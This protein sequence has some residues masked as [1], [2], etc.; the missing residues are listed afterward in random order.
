MLIKARH[1]VQK[2]LKPWPA[3]AIQLQPLA[4]LHPYPN[5]PNKHSPEQIELIKQSMLER[6]WTMPILIDEAGMILAGH[7]RVLAAQLLVDEGLKQFSK[8]PC[9]RAVG[10]SETDKRAYVLADNQLTRVSEW[11]PELLKLELNELIR[12]DYDMSLTGFD[13]LSLT[14]FATWGDDA[15]DPEETPE[16]QQIPVSQ[17]GD[18]WLLGKHRLLCGDCTKAKD[19][20]RALGGEA[21]HLMVTDP[22]YGVEYAAGWRNEAMPAKNDPTRWKD[23][24]G[25]AVGAVSNDDRADWREAWSRFPGD[26]IYT[27]HAGNKAHIVAEGLL[28]SGFELRAQI[29]W[30]KHQ[31]VIGRGHYHPQHEPCWYA[32]RRGAKGHWSG[33]RKQTTVWHIDK[34]HKS[35]TG[36]ST[37][38]PVE[39][40]K[41]PIDNNSKRGE[42]VYDPFVGSGT[43]IIAAE[44]SGRHC[45]ALE[46]NP[47]YVDVAVRRWQEFTSKAATLEGTNQTFEQVSRERLQLGRRH[48]KKRRARVR[49]AARPRKARGETPAMADA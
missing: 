34:P 25:R 49:R 33:D 23:G 36:H 22:P 8:A 32:V 44:M 20:E 40:M 18:V 9:V 47:L 28:G 45:V 38:K 31:L 4:S 16:V 29:I 11:D 15:K 6:G 3:S 2:E 43:T 19:V 24:A 37:Q 46:I 14:R 5:N 35:E 10:W 12:M 21:P 30:T 39:C 1:K 7:G 41:R 27:W 48:P 17:L 26:V 42:A 13:D